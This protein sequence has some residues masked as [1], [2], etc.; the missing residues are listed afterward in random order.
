MSP[1]PLGYATI[2]VLQAISDDFG[3][4][5]DV[6]DRTGLPSGTVYPALASLERRGLVKSRWEADATARAEARPRRRYYRVTREGKGAL[7]E[8]L[9]RLGALGLTVAPIDPTPEP[10]GG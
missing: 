4:G 8:A 7:A 2:A 3:Y 5:F 10:A 1:R 6:I 9:E